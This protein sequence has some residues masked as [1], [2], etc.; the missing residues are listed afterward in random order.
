MPRRRYATIGFILDE[1]EILFFRENEIRPRW[2]HVQVHP[3]AE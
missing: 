1:R 3:M 2:L